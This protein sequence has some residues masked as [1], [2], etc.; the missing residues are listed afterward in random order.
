LE[1]Q[2]E[3]L[4]Q[5][6]KEKET[7]R[8]RYRLNAQSQEEKR[9]KLLSEFNSAFDRYANVHDQVCSF[10]RSE[11]LRRLSTIDAEI[12]AIE[13][14]MND[15]RSKVLELRPALESAK[16]HLNERESVQKNIERNIELKAILERIKDLREEVSILMDKLES[17]DC[18]AVRKKLN[19]SME[20]IKKYEYEKSRRDG[21]KDTLMIHQR[22][23]KV[24]HSKDMSH[25]MNI[26]C[27]ILTF[28]L[29]RENSKQMSTKILMRG[30]A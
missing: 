20:L 27:A 18:E 26:I 13:F 6:A 25:S 10:F 4:R 23:L 8:S 30:I 15:Q 28:S 16:T 17:I 3:P 7:E 1:A 21:S 9:G 2:I 29:K 5:N 19:T 12:K 22:E 11:K 24:C 14:E